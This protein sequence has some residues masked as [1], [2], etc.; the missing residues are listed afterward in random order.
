MD[1][2]APFFTDVFIFVLHI[3]LMLGLGGHIMT[4]EF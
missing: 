2:D 4:A 1:H 3:G